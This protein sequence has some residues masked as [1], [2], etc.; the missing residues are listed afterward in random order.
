MYTLR[1]DNCQLLNTYLP[2]L[3]TADEVGFV[4]WRKFPNSNDVYLRPYPELW[5]LSLILQSLILYLIQIWTNYL[6]HQ[7]GL[8]I[9]TG[10]IYISIGIYDEELYNK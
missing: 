1:I 2:R 3:L 8:N 6:V 7:N 10:P 5:V 9:L 4:A